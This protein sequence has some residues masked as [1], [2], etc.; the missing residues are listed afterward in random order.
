MTGPQLF[1]E[2]PSWG[3]DAEK[4]FFTAEEGDIVLAHEGE[5]VL[6]QRS[7]ETMPVSW[8]L[9]GG[10]VLQINPAYFRMIMHTPEITAM[11]D[12]RCEELANEANSLAIKE[13]AEYIYQVSNNPA[14]IRARGRVKPGNYAAR[15]D[16]EHNGTL[17]K[18]LA[19]VGSD[20]LPPQY[21]GNEAYERYLGEHDEFHSMYA[22]QDAEVPEYLEIPDAAA[23][24]EQAARGGNYFGA[25]SFDPGD[26]EI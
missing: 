5:L 13:G 21:E 2:L 11:V 16:D 20:P 3:G 19:T 12:Q 25:A 17:L 18:A 6:E 9:G 4:V 7:D 22:M 8:D 23:V 26:V 10:I 24:D 1:G 14:N 15:I